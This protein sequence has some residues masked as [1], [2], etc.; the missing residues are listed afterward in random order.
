MDLDLDKTIS[1]SEDLEEEDLDLP[2]WDYVSACARLN[3]FYLSS[4]NS[5][6][7]SISAYSIFKFVS[8]M[9]VMFDVLFSE[10]IC[11]D[12]DANRTDSYTSVGA[13]E[14]AHQQRECFDIFLALDV[15]IN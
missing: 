3:R 8:P 5:I 2:L 11:T 7:I 6:I 1:E 14:E 10:R 4:Y 9:D 12:I 13:Q 15:G